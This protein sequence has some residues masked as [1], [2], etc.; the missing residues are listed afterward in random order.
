MARR[1]SYTAATVTWTANRVGVSWT[2]QSWYF[3]GASWT[4]IAARAVKLLT[5]SG[6]D[7]RTYEITGSEH[8]NF[9]QWAAKLSAALGKKVSYQNVPEEAL[10]Q[11]LLSMGIPTPIAESFIAFFSLIRNGK[12]YPP[13][14]AVA[15]LLGR[16]PRSF[17]EWARDN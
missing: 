9:G 3:H 12:I 11:G 5:T 2:D 15:D 1:H 10:R 14:S 6:H 17:D 8:L 13:I 7:G 16:Q 4:G